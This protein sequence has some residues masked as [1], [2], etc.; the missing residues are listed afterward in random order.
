M[1]YQK[2]MG[3]SPW[4]AIQYSKNY[5]VGLSFVSTAGHGGYRITERL[6]KE[7]AFFPEEI[8]RLGAIKQGNYYFFEED[9]AWAL[10]LNDCPSLCKL[11]AETDARLSPEELF[12][13]AH[14]TAKAWYPSY[15]NNEAA[16]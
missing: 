16:Q 5:C 11:V 6:L 13:M 9:C 4:G 14:E 1:Y 8:A 2:S 15:F 7:S 3:A 12:N 10:L